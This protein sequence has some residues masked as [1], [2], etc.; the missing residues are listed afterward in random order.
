MVGSVHSQLL[1]PKFGHRLLLSQ[2]M[3]GQMNEARK[4]V[5]S[6]LSPSALAFLRKRGAKKPATAAPMEAIAHESRAVPT[7]TV[8]EA[9]GAPQH[10]AIPAHRAEGLLLNRATEQPDGRHALPARPGPLPRRPEMITGH[11]EDLEDD[12][13][14]QDAH[15]CLCANFGN[16]AVTG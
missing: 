2:L 8:P 4:E 13:I 6:A 9:Q 7:A 11:L 14:Y 10:K 1:L 16:A 3:A 15:S 12:T 5:E